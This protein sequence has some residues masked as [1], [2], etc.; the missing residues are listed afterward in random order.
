MEEEFTDFLMETSMKVTWIKIKKVEEVFTS[1]E[2][3][4][5]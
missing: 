5:E 1:G 3:M 2:I 4:Q